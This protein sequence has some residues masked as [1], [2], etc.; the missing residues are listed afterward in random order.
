MISKNGLIAALCTMCITLLGMGIMFIIRDYQMLGSIIA[1]IGVVVLVF[2]SVIYP[3]WDTIKWELDE[4][5]RKKRES[6]LKDMMENDQKLGLYDLDM[7]DN[8]KA[9]I[10]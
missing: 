8:D 9:Q 5:D 7:D 10:G 6:Y 3:L 1:L 2:F 4:R